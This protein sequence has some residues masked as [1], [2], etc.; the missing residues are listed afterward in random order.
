MGAVWEEV[1]Q[2]RSNRLG[3][4]HEPQKTY[5]HLS[6]RGAGI[7]DPGGGADI[8]AIPCAGAADSAGSPECPKR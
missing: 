6:Q 4:E 3:P 7:L 1:A 5:Q 2:G 8:S